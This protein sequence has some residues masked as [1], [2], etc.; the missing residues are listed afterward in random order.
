RHYVGLSPDKL[1]SQE[2]AEE[3]VIAIPLAPRVERYE[4]EIRALDPLEQLDRV[5]ALRD[6][7]A[8]RPREPVENGCPEQ[9]RSDVIRLAGE[10]LVEQVVDDLPIIAGE[11]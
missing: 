4:E 1:V 7:I 5:G 11:R 8:E 2:L 3:M 6:G 9:E 10:H